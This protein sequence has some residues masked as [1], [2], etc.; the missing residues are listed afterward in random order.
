MHG[1]IY[2]DLQ[3]HCTARNWIHIT[4]SLQWMRMETSRAAALVRITLEFC[5]MNKVEL[6]RIPWA[7]HRRMKKGSNDSFVDKSHCDSCF[8]GCSLDH[9]ALECGYGLSPVGQPGLLHMCTCMMPANHHHVVDLKRFRPQNFPEFWTTGKNGWKTE[10][11]AVY[12][13]AMAFDDA[14]EWCKSQNFGGGGYSCFSLFSS[15]ENCL[16]WLKHE[17]IR[18]SKVKNTL[19]VICVVKTMVKGFVLLSFLCFCFCSFV[20]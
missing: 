6:Q 17:R 3:W 1:C 18:K 5:G 8:S 11:F 10:C 16:D 2:L 15:S 14:T 19:L 4:S 9:I 12:C 7:L 13:G 20:L